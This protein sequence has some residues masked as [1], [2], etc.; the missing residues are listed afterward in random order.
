[1]SDSPDIHLA[2][3]ASYVQGPPRSVR[4]ILWR[5]LLHHR[6][7]VASLLVLTA[8]TAIALAAPLVELALDLDANRVDL[9]ARFAPPSA[10]ACVNT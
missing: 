10:E 7:A 6:L 9:L 8:L 4:V 2:A 1:M 3:E 5:R